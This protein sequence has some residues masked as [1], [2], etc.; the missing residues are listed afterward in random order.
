MENKT[1]GA[2]M[3]MQVLKTKKQ[4]MLVVQKNASKDVFGELMAKAELKSISGFA[5][6]YK[7][8]LVDFGLIDKEVANELFDSVFVNEVLKKGA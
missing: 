1:K 3:L 5:V 7:Q 4:E 8:A 2:A 6:G